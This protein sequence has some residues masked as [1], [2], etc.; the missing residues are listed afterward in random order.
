LLEFF[1][2]QLK[3]LFDSF[4]EINT[5][6]QAFGS[7]VSKIQT[8]LDKGQ[9][10]ERQGIYIP[11]MKDK[12]VTSKPYKSHAYWEKTRNKAVTFFMIINL[13]PGDN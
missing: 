6:I 2:E 7:S 13:L 5:S 9:Q 8:V 12:E 1:K 11:N 4:L 10:M 3:K